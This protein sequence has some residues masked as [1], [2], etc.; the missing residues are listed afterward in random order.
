MVGKY[1][2]ALFSK[3]IMIKKSNQ[4]GIASLPQKTELPFLQFSRTVMQIPRRLFC[5][6]NKQEK[7]LSPNNLFSFQFP[8]TVIIYQQKCLSRWSTKVLPVISLWG[9]SLKEGGGVEVGGGG[10]KK[11]ESRE[12]A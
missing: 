1:R 3:I 7:D 10:V 9:R 6:A 5:L 11:L 4:W 12:S 2:Q 8:N